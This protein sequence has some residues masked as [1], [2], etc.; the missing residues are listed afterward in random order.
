MMVFRYA[1]TEEHI[2]E[3]WEIIGYH[4]GYPLYQKKDW[5]HTYCDC[6]STKECAGEQA[7]GRC[8]K[9]RST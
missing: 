8:K 9:W 1:L 4:N 3:D 2:P 6:P 5:K 7:E